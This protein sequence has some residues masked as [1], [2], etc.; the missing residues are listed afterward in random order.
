MAK[1]VVEF[2]GTF[3][4]V[5]TIGMTVINPGAGALA[6]LAI[7]SALMVMI[8]AGGHVSGAHYNPAVTLA[9]YMR[10]RCPLADVPGYMLAQVVGAIVAALVVGVLKGPAAMGQVTPGSPPIGPALL[11]EFVFTFAL[12]WTVLNV[13]TAKAT[14]GNSNYGLAIGFTVMTGA[15]A[16]GSVSGGVFNPAVA[17][18][19]TMM[20]LSAAANIW[21]FLVADFLGGAVAAY[22]FTTMNPKDR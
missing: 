4:L 6:P 1:Y 20:G 16:V 21:I 18:G 19:V 14:S 8:Y 2:V 11:A 9:V 10:G 3:F 7:G 22:A 13:A 15:F 5:L 17:V 12:A